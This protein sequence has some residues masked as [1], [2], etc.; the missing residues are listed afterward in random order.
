MKKQIKNMSAMALI[1][2][3]TTTVAYI[4]SSQAALGIATAIVS[5]VLGVCGILGGGALTMDALTDPHWG[6][7]F[8]LENNLELAI[9]LIFMDDEKGQ[10]VVFKPVTPSESQSIGLSSQE[11]SAYNSNIDELNDIHEQVVS[12]LSQIK[13]PTA[14]DSQNAWQKYEGALSPEAISAAQKVVKASIHQQSK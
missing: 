1:L 6:G 11:M 9:G 3:A 12:D 14:Q 5:P 13:S 7:M 4:P 2:A 8:W 10:T